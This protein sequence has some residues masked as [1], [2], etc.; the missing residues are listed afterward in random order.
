[1]NSA[2]HIP[3][4]DE[5]AASSDEPV[6]VEIYRPGVIE[7]LRDAWRHRR[8]ALGLL[9]Q[10]V[11]LRV[12]RMILGVWWVPIGIAFDIVVKAFVFGTVLS[13]PSTGDVPY[14]IFLGLGSMAWW[15]FHRGSLY[16]M[17]SFQAFRHFIVQFHFPL[18]L[19][20]IAGVAAV[21]VAVGFYSIFLA[22]AFVVYWVIDGELYLNVSPMLLLAP[23]ALAWLALFAAII[24]VF[25]AP[26]Y[27]RARDIRMVFRLFLPF[28]MFVTPIIYPLSKLSDVD[29][30]I[31]TLAAL[32]PL[33]PPVELLR[34]AAL[35]S[36]GVP[37]YSWLSGIVVTIGL[38]FGA[39]AFLN[40]YSLR[41][42]GVPDEDDLEDD[43][44]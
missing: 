35:G 6:Q 15:L 22:I 17:K 10:T 30:T 29:P 41:L 32:N 27:W 33:A 2:M 42:I 38:L 5:R 24:G 18:L 31:G 11:S 12:P 3:A 23:V 13:A 39:L 4:A 28:W 9:R 7:T 21:F 37:L 20:P 14:L 34:V 8:M 16:S 43:L 36:G 25:T 44:A 1:M 19:V 26:V 40:R